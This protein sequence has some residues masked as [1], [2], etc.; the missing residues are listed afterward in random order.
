MADVD[1]RA[2]SK[3]TGGGGENGDSSATPA[4]MAGAVLLMLAIGAGVWWTLWPQDI[5]P[6]KD[7]GFADNVFAS[8]PVVFAARLILL[9]SGVVLAVGGLFVVVSIAK[10][11]TALRWFTRFGPFE[12]SPEAIGTLAEEVE[13]GVRTPSSRA[14]WWASYKSDCKR[15]TSCWAGLS[16]SAAIPANKCWRRYGR[17]LRSE[18]Q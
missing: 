7:P 10:L 8:A 11:W 3:G 9:S 6:A 2:V 5:P 15:P 1:P 17:S 4:S 12:A 16:A 18:E 13:S 14:K